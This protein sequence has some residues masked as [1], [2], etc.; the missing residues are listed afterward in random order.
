MPQ[1][2]DI[3][4]IL[5]AIVA[6]IS[7]FTAAFWASLVIW[8][9]RDMRLRSRDI[10]A[11]LLAS[12]VVL[13]FGPLGLLIYLILRPQETLSEAYARTLEEEALLQDI[14]EEQPVCPECKHRI[15]PDFI[16]CPACH[17]ELRKACP[18]CGRLSLMRW[19]VCPYC[20]EPYPLP[21]E[22]EL[23]EAELDAGAD[24]ELEAVPDLEVEPEAEIEPT[25]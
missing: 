13:I 18:H 21:P 9:F 3:G 16:I 22:P 25:E 14:T 8:T 24:F 10:F 17:T 19:E 12:L 1:L 4:T 5:L 15:E 2:E 20:A 23:A 6:F 11:Q 7:A